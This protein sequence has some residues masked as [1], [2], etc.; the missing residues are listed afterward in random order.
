MLLIERAAQG[1]YTSIRRKYRQNKKNIV[2]FAGPG[3][4]GAIALSLATMLTQDDYNT[5][6]YLI[7]HK[8]HISPES[9][10]YRLQMIERGCSLNEVY[11]KFVIPKLN[12]Q[13]DLIIDALFGVGLYAP[14]QTGGFATL[15][16]IINGSKCEILSIDLPSGMMSEHNLD[17]D[18]NKIIKANC[19][20]SIENPK[21]SFF[22]TENS[23]YI[24]DI[25]VI[26]LGIS[27]EVKKK[28]SSTMF[29]ST[30]MTISNLLKETLCKNDDKLTMP[31]MLIG[32]HRYNVGNLLASSKASVYSGAKDVV[33]QVPYS[34]IQALQVYNPQVEIISKKEPEL[35]IS[36]IINYEGK[37]IVFAD[38][39]GINQDTV[40]SINECIKNTQNPIVISGEMTNIFLSRYDMLN[41]IPKGSIL[42]MSKE[43][44]SYLK[45]SQNNEYDLI[46][47]VKI[48]ANKYN[49]CI[50]LKLSY[51]CTVMPS[52]NIFFNDI[53]N[54]DIIGT[55]S[56]TAIIS[57]VI[58][59][60][61]SQ[62]VSS[63]SATI[64]GSYIVPMAAD[65]A[66]GN[67]KS[68]NIGIEDLN[69]KINEAINIL[70]S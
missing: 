23:K 11:D 32:G 69:D 15:I 3:N 10:K 20:L 55:K 1:I 33:C 39:L 37:T 40:F 4:T 47:Q 60:L 16:D 66:C 35:Y 51:N 67:K 9:E 19:T 22:F 17:Y 36:K 68:L 30:Q 48:L 59:S 43:N 61:I 5:S 8:K 12:E 50:L 14:I 58:G 46:E 45:I 63:V 34:A 52:G 18:K 64:I 70:I 44:L 25:S 6:T 27:D 38:N 54:R 57:A 28:L 26:S 29:V 62:G 42:V 56:A 21:L 53:K 7:Y 24:G 31:L 65:I 49:I 41:N 2:I 13:K